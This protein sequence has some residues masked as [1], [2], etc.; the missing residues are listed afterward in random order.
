MERSILWIPTCWRYKTACFAN[1]D[2]CRLLDGTQVFSF[3]YSNDLN[4]TARPSECMI[5]IE[6]LACLQFLN[7]PLSRQGE[8]TCLFPHYRVIYRQATC[9]QATYKS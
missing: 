8:I 1:N 7:G 2:T 6:R 4:L 3:P 9:R 5:M